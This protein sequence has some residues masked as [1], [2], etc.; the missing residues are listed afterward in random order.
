MPYSF[1]SIFH[2]NKSIRRCDDSIQFVISIRNW[3]TAAARVPRI[4]AG[5]LRHDSFCGA[6]HAGRRRLNWI[7]G[8]HL[9]VELTWIGVFIR[10]LEMTQRTRFNI[11]V[12]IYIFISL[13]TK[14]VQFP[15]YSCIYF[16]KEKK[17]K[18]NMPYSNKPIRRCDDS[19]QF[20]ISIHNWSTAAARVPRIT[21]GVPRHDSFC[22]AR[23]AG[24]R[25]LN[26]IAGF[27][28]FV[29]L[30]WIGDLIRRLE[31][32]QRTRFNIWVY[33]YIY[34]SF[35]TKYVQFQIYLCIYFCEE[36]KREEEHAL[37]FF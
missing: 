31:M 34:I 36:K 8:F 22:G 23:H 2:V 4:T 37:L 15:N 32:S 35:H 12:Y 14:Y 25:R 18:K 26:W 24:S 6:R 11:W 1:S 21:A 16:C 30:T 33:I 9:F 20:V 29:D 10:R 27:N 7:A 19:I 5:V 28:L 13:H 3:S 17:Q